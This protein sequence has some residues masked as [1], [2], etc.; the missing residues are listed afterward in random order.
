MIRS[1]FIIALII[2]S[3]SGFSQIKD[4]L[5][6]SF[7][8]DSL[9][10]QKLR[11]M[12]SIQYETK[13][14]YSTLKHE[15]DSIELEFSLLADKLQY[16][17]DSLNNLNLPVESLTSRI[18]SIN[19][20]KEQKLSGLK[21]KAEELKHTSRQRIADLDLPPKINAK[22]VEYATVLDKLDISLPKTELVFPS[23]ELDGVPDLSLPG[24]TNSLSSGL[25]DLNVLQVREEFD[26]VTNTVKD[27]Q[28]TIPE[29]PTTNDI[30]VEVEN[31]AGELVAEQLGELPTTPELP[32][33]GET[34]KEIVVNEIKKQAI[35][36]FAGQQQQ[37]Q[38]AMDQMSKY[39]QKYSSV[40]SIKDLPKK[41]PNAMKGKPLRERLV[42]GFTLQVQRRNDWW[43]D[44]NPYMGYKLSG[45][46]TAGLGWNQR[47]PYDLHSGKYNRSAIIYG[48]RSYSEYRLKKGGF[49]PRIE[50]EC[51]NTPVRTPPDLSY[52]HREWVWSAMAGI[53]KEYRIS[54]SLRG[55][56]QVLFN[57]FDPY[58]KSPYTDKLNMRTGVEYRI[59]KKKRAK[60]S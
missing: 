15:Y 36:H 46:L 21:A 40:Q 30:A 26:Q 57:L 9:L 31:K 52:N 56:A 39:K 54:K 60:T 34:A 41:V 18:D 22:L 23:F 2:V 14:Q 28:N 38:A 24:I 44:L 5:T 1:I 59:P 51:M 7:D 12:D 42:P 4:S 47:L 53:K 16:Q 17:A 37:L 45:R 13:N 50:I 29:T 32:S 10:L 58:Y 49:A 25:D 8:A 35:D 48:P 19:N 6:L 43:F 11:I 55:N 3:R 20:L 33:N 27:L